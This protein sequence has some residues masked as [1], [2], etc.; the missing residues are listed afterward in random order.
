MNQSVEN[1]F[2]IP[3]A[4][5]FLFYSPL[6]GLSA[7]MNRSG[8]LELKEQLRL[9]DKNQ[10]NTESGLYELAQDIL[11]R[12]IQTPLRKTG[13]LNPEFLGIIPTRY[14]NGACNYCDF[15]ANKA[16]PEKMSYQL[17]AKIV[18][19]Y[20]AVLKLKQRNILEIHFFGGEPMVA[21]DVIEVVVQRARLV[22]ME[23]NLVPFFEISTNGQYN[24]NDS[25][26]LG[27][28][29]NKVIL[30]LDGLEEI[31]NKHRPLKANRSSFQ[32]AVET[33]KV[34]SGSNADLCIRC[35]V[36]IENIL[37][38]E[39]F[40]EW[41]CTHFKLSAIN[42]EILCTTAR[43]DSVGLFPPDPV[44]FAIHFQKSREI[45]NSY[46][47]EVVYASDISGQPLISSCPVGKDTAIVSPDGRISNCYLMPEKWQEVGL[48]LDFGIF[49]ING[50]VTIET[51]KVDFIRNMVERKPRCNKCFC[52]W[53]CAGG[54]HVGITNPG[55]RL[56]YD[57]FCFQT[58]LI[59]AFTLLAN[60]GLPNK[61][62][63][64][65]LSNNALHKIAHQGTDHIQAF[66]D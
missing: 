11:K 65:M 54:C 37:N 63:E 62:S 14:C 5:D 19:W 7:L 61:I 66:K 16:S 57:N 10:G 26:F 9:I 38:M 32:N 12:P 45:A 59:S 52:Q 28:Y 41:L 21:R 49:K 36:S 4:N 18:D 13:D 64:L 25:Q 48:D 15:G 51:D 17:A 6:A 50:E 22:A 33:A 35:C 42:F 60:L 46:G 39:E 58:R 43:T 1:S 55:S 20:V 24:A 30:S 3:I 29:F 53:S 34:I 40:T 44:K 27:Q 56:E 47:I 23:Q 31:Q 2:I 8:V